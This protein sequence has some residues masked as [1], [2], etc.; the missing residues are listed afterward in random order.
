MAEWI[1]PIFD[2]TLNDVESAIRQIALQKANGVATPPELK[3]CLNMGDLNRIEK[4]IQFLSDNLSSLYYFSKVTTKT[5]QRN[6]LPTA[7]EITRIL[8]NIRILINSFYQSK[9]APDLPTTVLTYEHL[10]SIEENLY[11]LKEMLDN[12]VASFREC[13]TLYCG[14]E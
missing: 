5:W 4:D 14:E 13:G 1:E 2:R 6:N 7:T 11:L 12:M 8:N 9:D 3:G 10:N